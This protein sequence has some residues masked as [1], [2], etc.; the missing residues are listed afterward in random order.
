MD[1][2]KDLNSGTLDSDDTEDLETN[3]TRSPNG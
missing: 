3:S 1:I 2:I